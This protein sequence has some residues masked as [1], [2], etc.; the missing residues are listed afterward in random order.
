MPNDT[1]LAASYEHCRNLAKAAA[2]NFYYGF[3]L[4]PAPKRD[5]LC[6][7]YAFM[8]HADDIS[9]SEGNLQDKGKGLRAWRN[10][11]DQALLGNYN[12]SKLLP[13]FH[14][15]IER[16]KI[17]AEYFHDLMSGAEMDLSVR[18]Y[19]TFDDLSRY[20]YCVAGTVGLCCIHVFGFRDP[21]ALQLAPKL[22]IA[23]QMTNIL[24]DVA[25]D[26]SMG[27]VYLPQEDLKR[28]GCTD[29]D[30]SDRVGSP[31]FIQLMRFEAD[32]AWRLYEEG[33]QLLNMI[34][35]DSRSSLWTLMRIYSGI[36]AKIESI[37]YDVLAQPHPGLS[38]FQKAWIMLRAGAGLWKTGLCPRHT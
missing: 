38:S 3:A 11:L 22:G 35:N 20:C 27:R 9:D 6:A 34:D 32:R 28:F 25:E 5:A 33:A 4:L 7:L 24:R 31:A 2:R 19:E 12:G 26:Y 23:F 16:Y 8:R 17:P 1:E 10:A 21:K 18:T 13:A 37:H 36:L 15:T 14:N 30:L 29:R